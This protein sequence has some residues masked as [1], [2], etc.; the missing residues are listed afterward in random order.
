MQRFIQSK[1]YICRK[2]IA[3][4]TTAIV[5]KVCSVGSHTCYAA[6]V[7]VRFACRGYV[8]IGYAYVRCIGGQSAIR[9]LF[10]IVLASR[11]RYIVC[12]FRPTCFLVECASCWVSLSVRIAKYEARS[13]VSV[14]WYG[15]AVVAVFYAY[16]IIYFSVVIIIPCARNAELPSLRVTAG[17]L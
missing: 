13:Y 6:A 2:S 3:T 8:V 14:F 12:D 5:R 1:R 11:Y 9:V 10:D 17:H 4:A 16:C 15:T 7:L